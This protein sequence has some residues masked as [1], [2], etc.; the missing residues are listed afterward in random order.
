MAM[1][2]RGGRGRGGAGRLIDRLREARGVGLRGL[3]PLERLSGLPDRVELA[4]AR[5]ADNQNILSAA[6]LASQYQKALHKKAE[7]LP[8]Q[9]VL[10]MITVELV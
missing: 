5:S 1:R 7:C 9:Q 4:S 2:R 8:A 6:R 3:S 10:E